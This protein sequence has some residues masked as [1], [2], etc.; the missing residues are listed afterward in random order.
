MIEYAKKELELA[1]YYDEDS[2]YA[3]MLPDAVLEIVEVFAN[4]NHSG[5]SAAIVLSLLDKLLRFKPLTPLTG[6]D[7]EWNEVGNGVYQ[8]K[9]CS[10][11]FKENGKAYFLDALIFIDENGLSF[12]G[13]VNDKNWDVVKSNQDIVFPFVP[14]SFYLDVVSFPSHSGYAVKSFVELEK[15]MDY[16]ETPYGDKEV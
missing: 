1:G 15:A 13:T 6:E 16:F 14:K 10:S 3:G 5:M 12:T 11:V 7:D 8:N 2:D 9:R 4:Q